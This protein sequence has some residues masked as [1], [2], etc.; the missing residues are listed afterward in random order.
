MTMDELMHAMKYEGAYI[1]CENLKQ[2]VLLLASFCDMGELCS[3]LATGYLMHSK[4]VES[5]MSKLRLAV[6]WNIKYGFGIG[7]GSGSREIRFGEIADLFNGYTLP[8]D[9][10]LESAT[11]AELAELIGVGV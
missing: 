3:A 7:F 5:M 10:T 1:Q 6:H 2:I 8:G 11:D 4:L 9:D